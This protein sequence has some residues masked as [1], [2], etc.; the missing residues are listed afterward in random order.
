M[1]EYTGPE[2]IVLGDAANVIRGSKPGIGDAA[3]PSH[4]VLQNEL[5]ED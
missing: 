4:K 3:D 5:T 1:K 2:M